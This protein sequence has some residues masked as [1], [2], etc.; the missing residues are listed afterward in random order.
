V[1]FRRVMY[2][3]RRALTGGAGLGALG[4]LAVLDARGFFADIRLAAVDFW[5]IAALALLVGLLVSRL[6]GRIVEP[7]ATRPTLRDHVRDFE[8]GLTLVV[9]TW[10]ILG[11]TGGAR[12]PVY[13][14]VYV[15]VAYLVAFHRVAVGIPLVAAMVSLELAT[16]S[17]AAAEMGHVAFIVLFALVNL[18][19]L[20]AEVWR[21]RRE[22]RD[23][24]DREIRAMREEAR[25]FRLISS[26]LGA[27]SRTRTRAEEEAKL[28]QGAVETIHQSLFYTLE[29]LKKSLDLHTCVLLWLDDS[30]E[31]LRI[32]ELVTDSDLLTERDVPADA[33][34]LGACI[35]D[36][37]LINL[38]GPQRGQIP[39]YRGP[40]DIGA[41]V[42]VP[43]DEDGHLRG[44]LAAD[45]RT[46]RAFD[47]KDEALLV[48]AARQILRAIQSERVFAAVERSKYEKER[49]FRAS[50]MLNQALTLEQVY[51]V[52][53][54]AA[55]EICDF[56]FAAITLVTKETRKHTITFAVGD[57]RTELEN[58]TFSDNAGLAAMVVK[59]KHYLPVGG[60]RDAIGETPV[61][62]KKVKALRGYSSLLVLPLVC[63][64]DAIGSFTIAAR[65]RGVFGKDKRDMLG[66]IANQVA[67][68]IENAK[69]YK[70]M[71]EMATT[72]GLTGLLNHRTFQERILGM[73]DRS[74][75]LSKNCALILCDIDHFKKINDTYGHPIGDV[76]LKRVAKVL[77]GCVRK[78]DLV[79][80]Y[81]GEEFA[82]VLEETGSM[83]ARELAERIRAE[84]QKQQFTSEKGNFAI[85]MSLGIAAYP[86]DGA[87]KQVLI[88]HADQALYYAKHN[89][90]NRSI[91]YGD[92]TAAKAKLALRSA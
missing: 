4:L 69:M 87:E 31:R 75:R 12:S 33:G 14:L 35:K 36:R 47:E 41:F 25:D 73:I 81:G 92:M 24:I 28:A 80:R 7:V 11:M 10:A 83:G 74:E 19:F 38:R 91:S 17:D 20:H 9:S 15:L 22:S 72:D 86:D 78:I 59:N 60:D 55:R 90:R 82:L 54:R 88:E 43:L 77:A 40:E 52:A 30:G 61:F 51:E 23:R 18:V 44:V 57:G 46:Q 84:V 64:D 63:A 65:R 2:K 26:A 49:F 8:F 21:S 85:T 16:N 70:M 71:E 37:V 42:A 89:G 79:A 45:R 32:K 6:A 68:S 58:L 13:P 5:Q 50:E 1:K 29:L 56:D 62:T 34:A 3:L 27:E 39:Y 66:V 48:G 67:V 76:V 53:V